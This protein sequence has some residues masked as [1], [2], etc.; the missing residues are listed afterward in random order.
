MKEA[1]KRTCRLCHET[2]PLDLFE[3]DM[4]VKGGITSRCKAC[5]A[6]MNDRAGAL[7]ANMRRR[8]AIDGSTVDVTREQI[9]ALYEAFD[10]KC[11]YCG[12]E[13]DGEGRRH[14]VD[15]VIP[16]SRGGMHHLS[17]LVLAC[18]SCNPSKGNKPLATFFIDKKDTGD[19]PDEHFQ[20]IERFLS[21]MAGIPPAEY[22]D[23]LLQE[24][25]EYTV[26]RMFRE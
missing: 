5:K 3:N 19:F 22:R 26:E 13:E 10:G 1:K 15:H 11:A 21:V 17:N 6:G 18:N 8:A 14:A 7:L 2:K 24:H 4:R 16:V 12:A 9:N 25:A 20:M 23:L